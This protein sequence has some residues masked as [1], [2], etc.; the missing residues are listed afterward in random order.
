MLLPLTSIDLLQ[1]GE[2]GGVNFWR[3][4]RIPRASAGSDLSPNTSDNQPDTR[5]IDES[6]T[7]VDHQGLGAFRRRAESHHV[8]GERV[9]KRD[10]EKHDNPDEEVRRS[11]H[12]ASI[13]PTGLRRLPRD[14]IRLGA[15]VYPVSL[16]LKNSSSTYLI[17][18][19]GVR[20]ADRVTSGF[21]CVCCF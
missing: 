5:C 14:E 8:P 6:D 15:P 18:G 12:A 10:R 21:L 7:A 4:A 9:R 19:R 20:C 17:H 13:A 16:G 11:Q 3:G 1:R 2:G